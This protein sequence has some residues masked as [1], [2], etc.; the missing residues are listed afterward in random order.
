MDVR[1]EQQMDDAPA[2]TTGATG[3]TGTTEGGDLA[4]GVGDLGPTAGG[5]AGGSDIGGIGGDTDYA[6][7]VGGGSGSDMEDS[8]DLASRPRTDLDIP[9][10]TVA[11]GE[12]GTEDFDAFGADVMETEGG[13][14]GGR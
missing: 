3:T 5:I 6:T 4:G 2:A 10:G 7:G 14:D 13:R 9:G 11:G 8:P 1:G 12:T